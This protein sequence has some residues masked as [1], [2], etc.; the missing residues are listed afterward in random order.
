VLAVDDDAQVVALL[1]V[2]LRFCG[3]NTD[4][5]GMPFTFQ[6]DR[7]SGTTF[8]SCCGFIAARDLA[9]L[10]AGLTAVGRPTQRLFVDL[11]GAN[12]G[13]PYPEIEWFAKLERPCSRVAI[14]A[15]RPVAF[16]V[17]RMYQMLSSSGGALAIFSDRDKALAW[18]RRQ[19]PDE[20]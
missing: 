6:V 17:S 13:L 3:Y 4:F 8:V 2:M 16:G 18:L 19:V 10:H 1:G 20:P 7:E 9:D 14:Y 15:P 11:H 5:A 12:L